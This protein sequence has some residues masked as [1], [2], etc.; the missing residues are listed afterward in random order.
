MIYL[1]AAPFSKSTDKMKGLEQRIRCVDA[2]PCANFTL[3][4]LFIDV[5]AIT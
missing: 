3:I 5:Q 2:V 1:G 4:P